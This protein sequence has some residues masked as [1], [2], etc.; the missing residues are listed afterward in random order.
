MLMDH[1]FPDYICTKSTHLELTSVA[2]ACCA[3]QWPRWRKE[4]NRLGIWNELSRHPCR[5]T[6]ANSSFRVNYDVDR[7]QF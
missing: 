5:F 1:H 3:A 7:V 6:L 2:L 4:E